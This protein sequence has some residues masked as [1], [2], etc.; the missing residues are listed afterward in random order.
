MTSTSTATPR[1]SR[2]IALTPS[3]AVAPACRPICYGRHITRAIRRSIRSLKSRLSLAL[4]TSS[5]SRRALTLPEVAT[6][7]NGRV[8]LLSSGETGEVFTSSVNNADWCTNTA[9]C[10][11][12]IGLEGVVPRRRR[13]RRRQRQLRVEQHE[14]LHL[15]RVEVHNRGNQ[16]FRRSAPTRRTRSALR[17]EHGEHR[18]EQVHPAA[19][20]RECLRRRDR[21]SRLLRRRAG[22]RRRYPDQIVLRL[23][24]PACFPCHR[25]MHRLTRS[26]GDCGWR[27]ALHLEHDDLEVRRSD[28]LHQRL[29]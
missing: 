28:N 8:F 29:R 17:V 2:A 11:D 13:G 18:C 25:G 9:V 3:P 12:R 6:V 1:S 22:V 21:P 10:R 26:Q 15:H 20:G 5:R 14:R 27:R 7:Y 19:R 16:H 23:L 4:P 24:T